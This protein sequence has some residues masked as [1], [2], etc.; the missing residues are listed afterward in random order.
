[1][2]VISTR[3]QLSVCRL[4]GSCEITTSS[5]WIRGASCGTLASFSCRWRRNRSL[6]STCRPV[7]TISTM[8]L[9]ID[10]PDRP[11]PD[12]RDTRWT[13]TAMGMGC[14]RPRSAAAPPPTS[15]RGARVVRAPGDPG[16][17][18]RTHALTVRQERS[19]WQPTRGRFSPGRASSPGRAGAVT[20]GG[21]QRDRTHHVGARGPQRASRLDQRRA[22]GDDVVDEHDGGPAACARPRP[23]A[24]AARRRRSRRA[25]GRRQAGLVGHPPSHPQ[26]RPEREI[27]A[28]GL[29]QPAHHAARQVVDRGPPAATPGGGASTARAPARRRPVRRA[30]TRRATACA[31]TSV[32]SARSRSFHA[33]DGVPHDPVVPRRRPHARAVGQLAGRG[34]LGETRRAAGAPP[35]RRRPAAGAP[36]REHQVG[37]RLQGAAET[38]PGHCGIVTDVP[39]PS[40]RHPL[41]VRTSTAPGPRDDVHRPQAVAGADRHARPAASAA[42]RPDRP[43]R[44]GRAAPVRVHRPA[45]RGWCGRPTRRRARRGATGQR[46]AG[47]PGSPGR[48]VASRTMPATSQPARPVGG[49]RDDGQPRPVA[50]DVQGQH[51]APAQ[52]RRP[53]HAH[54]GGLPSSCGRRRRRGDDGQRTGLGPVGGPHPAADVDHRVDEVAARVAAGGRLLGR[55]RQQP[56]AAAVDPEQQVGVGAGGDGPQSRRRRCPRSVRWVRRPARRYRGRPGAAG[57]RSAPRPARRRGRHRSTPGHRPRPCPVARPP[58]RRHPRRSAR[59]RS[60]WAADAALAVS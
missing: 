9:L 34:W 4:L 60:P 50:R 25:R 10:A 11:L 44:P 42:R 47:W 5:R 58:G 32:T 55:E 35:C 45:R 29:P 30:G 36:A 16:G 46:C 12:G 59:W 33:F 8:D 24:R 21:R 14:S 31:S 40:E 38:S 41:P 17:G 43:P 2:Q 37:G 54:A 20:L 48:P 23:A 57:L 1:M 18:P 27:G 52:P 19:P 7:T 15:P 28:A 22:A 53:Q 49:G 13:V 26:H 3:S 56:A 6:T 51:P 39:A